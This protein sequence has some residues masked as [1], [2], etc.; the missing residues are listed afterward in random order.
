MSAAF[1]LAAVVLPHTPQGEEL[2][3]RSQ[4]PE[5]VVQAV[6]TE[7]R[8]R[9]DALIAAHPDRVRVAVIDEWGDPQDWTDPDGADEFLARGSRTAAERAQVALADFLDLILPEQDGTYGPDEDHATI[10]VFGGKPWLLVGES[11]WGDVS[12][13]YRLCAFMEQL[14]LFDEPMGGPS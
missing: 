8:A 5:D 4:L 13:E 10:R 7:A 6:R 9:L 11:S 2:A 1:V 14:A 12:E 3:C